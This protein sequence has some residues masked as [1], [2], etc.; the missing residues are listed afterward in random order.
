MSETVSIIPRDRHAAVLPLCASLAVCVLVYLTLR[1]VMHSGK[2][3]VSLVL[4]YCLPLFNL[5]FLLLNTSLD[6]I[7]FQTD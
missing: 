4:I 1:I 5:I 7:Q 6:E 3:T 2:V